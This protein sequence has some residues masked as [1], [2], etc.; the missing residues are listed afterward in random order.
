MWTVGH[1][2][3]RPCAAGDVVMGFNIPE[4]MTA[5]KIPVGVSYTIFIITMPKKLK[6]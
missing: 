4:K 2:V 6:V 1:H 5:D 3:V